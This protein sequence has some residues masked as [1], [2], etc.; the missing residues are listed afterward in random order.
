MGMC[1]KT[2]C[3]YLHKKVNEKTKICLDFLRGYCA[4]ADKVTFI[5]YSIAII[6]SFV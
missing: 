3:P 1:A 2:D 4:L 5:V 6:N